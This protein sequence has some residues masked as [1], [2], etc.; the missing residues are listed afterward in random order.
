MK[1]PCS[2][3]F[4]FVEEKSNGFSYLEA[5]D[6]GSFPSVCPMWLFIAKELQV[7]ADPH[8][9][10]GNLMQEKT[11]RHRAFV[12][13]LFL[14]RCHGNFCPTQEVIRSKLVSFED[15]DAQDVLVKILDVKLTVEVPLGVESVV[16][17]PG[18]EDL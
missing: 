1:Q 16:Q 5:S 15:G 17:R 10:C 12:F 18:S 6:E 2:S 9:S 3:R 7:E 13:Q 14:Y 8:L 11:A 4:S